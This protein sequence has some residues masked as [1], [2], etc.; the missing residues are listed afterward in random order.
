MFIAIGLEWVNVLV[1]IDTLVKTAKVVEDIDSKY[2]NLCI[3][4]NIWAKIVVDLLKVLDRS[5]ALFNGLL[6]LFYFFFWLAGL[7]AINRLK[8]AK[9]I[10]F[11]PT[12]ID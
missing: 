11:I 2:K 3:L 9:D 10:A 8:P 12:K 5:I 7:R 4:T 6:I 1:T